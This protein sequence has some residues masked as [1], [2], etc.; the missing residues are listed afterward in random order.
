MYLFHDI[1]RY[2]NDV[3]QDSFVL[4][5]HVVS[6]RNVGNYLPNETVEIQEDLNA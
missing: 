5:C 6:Y 3:A 2:Q 1:W 4:G